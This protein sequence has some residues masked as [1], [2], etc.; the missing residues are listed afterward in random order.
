MPL[1]HTIINKLTPSEKCTP[2]RPDKHSDGDG[3]QLW[4]QGKRTLFEK[5]VRK[6]SKSNKVI[7]YQR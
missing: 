2:N 6:R 4:V 7:G 3:L 5:V 1:T